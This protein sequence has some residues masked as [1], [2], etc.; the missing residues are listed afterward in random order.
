MKW[1]SLICVLSIHN[2]L[3]DDQLPTRGRVKDRQPIALETELTKSGSGGTVRFSMSVQVQPGVFLASPAS[4]GAAPIVDS[5]GWPVRFLT[6][7]ATT[8]KQGRVYRP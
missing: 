2:S 6:V 1:D 5:I 7:S 4:G 3:Y 8:R